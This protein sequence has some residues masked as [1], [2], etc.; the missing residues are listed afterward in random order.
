[1]A[2]EGI[3]GFEGEFGEDMG[4]CMF[5]VIETAIEGTGMVFYSS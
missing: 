5:C 2:G 3:M 4:D 1:V